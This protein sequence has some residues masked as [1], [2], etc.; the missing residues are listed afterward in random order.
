MSSGT[1]DAFVLF[2]ASGDLAKKKLFPSLY[3]L[4]QSSRL[5]VPVVGVALDDWDDSDLR[6]YARESIEQAMGAVDEKLFSHLA[7]QLSM[8]SGDYREQNT[9]RKLASS[10]EDNAR[11]VHYLAIPPS[12]FDDVVQGLEKAG[13]SDRSRIIVEKPFGHDLASAKSLNKVIQEVFPEEAVFRIDHYLGKES[14][15]NLLVFRFGNR[16]LEPLWNQAHVAQVQITM[17]ESFGIEGRGGFYDSAGTVRDVVQNHLLQVVALLAME[18]PVSAEADALRD[19]KVKVLKSIRSIDPEVMVRGQYDGYRLEPGVR[20]DST[21]ETFVALKL[22]IDS[23]RWAGV[24]F[25]VRAGKG[26]PVTSLEAVVEFHPPPRLLF[27]GA[28]AHR[29]QPNLFRFRLGAEDGVTMSVQAKEPGPDMKS[30]P[31]ELA[32]DFAT[33]LERREDAYARL[34]EAALGGDPTR[35]A[36]QDA[37]EEAW[38]IVEP[39]IA[40]SAS[41]LPYQRE[42]W[43]PQEADR[44]LPPGS[45]WYRPA[46]ATAPRS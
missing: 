18:P 10:L 7:S 2:G 12:L 9:F 37:V 14:I 28:H 1:A 38:R 39:A 22:D 41:P 3:R 25:F 34:I 5:D 24:P 23:W 44:I 43:G 27:C 32:V 45:S 19:E 31:V 46:S 33:A 17:A 36:R 4:A 13:L 35:F 29:P 40:S 21:T 30:H 11:P 6:S 20:D 26:L 42:T 16:F 15:E 8:V